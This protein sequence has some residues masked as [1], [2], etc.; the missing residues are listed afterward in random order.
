[1]VRGIYKLIKERREHKTAYRDLFAFII[2]TALYMTVLYLQ[3]GSA[4]RYQ[5]TQSMQ[6]LKP[7]VSIY[8][9]LRKG[10]QEEMGLS[11]T[12]GF[13]VDYRVT[14]VVSLTCLGCSRKRV[15]DLMTHP[16][17]LMLPQARGLLKAVS[18]RR[19][20][21]MGLRI[22]GTDRL[23]TIFESTYLAASVEPN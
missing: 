5:V 20:I 22:S 8:S 11:R 21:K 23:S 10:S 19:V 3:Q 1:V 18:L 16:V 13:V 17:I 7:Q 9:V 6:P 4:Q 15:R 12:M 2:F 14:R